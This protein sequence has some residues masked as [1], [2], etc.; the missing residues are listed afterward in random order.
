VFAN[1]AVVPP[2]KVGGFINS[3]VT[4]TV[5]V[6]VVTPTTIVTQIGTGTLGDHGASSH[7]QIS[8]ERAFTS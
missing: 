8:P 3:A 2:V 7:R 4:G 6:S 5:A 1:A